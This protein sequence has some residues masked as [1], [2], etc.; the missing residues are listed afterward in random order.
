MAQAIAAGEI[1]DIAEARHVIR[2]SFE[3]VKY[4]PNHSEVW[5]EGYERFCKLLG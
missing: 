4:E 1:K 2:N 3:I 5:D